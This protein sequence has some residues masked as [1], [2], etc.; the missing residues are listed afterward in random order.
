MA[1]QI[2]EFSCTECR[3]IFDIKLNISLNGKF[4]IHCP[5]C[6]HI[7]YREVVDGKIT[8]GRFTE[9]NTRDSRFIEDIKPMKSS[10]R[11]NQKETEKDSYFNQDS[12]AWLHQLWAEKFSGQLNE[13]P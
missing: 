4:R 12:A 8:E 7:H 5:N 9:L 13:C 6:N 1:R 2:F 3:K 11:D 10:C